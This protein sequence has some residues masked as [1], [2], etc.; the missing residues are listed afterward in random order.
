MIF[1]SGGADS[2][3]RELSERRRECQ[4]LYGKN[5]E[6]C[7]REEL[8]EKRCAAESVCSWEAKRFYVNKVQ[9]LGTCAEWAEAFAFPE[10]AHLRESF[11]KSS[12]AQCRKV[13]QEL[14]KC[15]QKRWT[16]RD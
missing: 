14:A 9:K 8:A 16:R 3:C 11:T 2:A 12:A 13:V 1:F 7:L 5:G 10:N 15:L 4:R 6:N